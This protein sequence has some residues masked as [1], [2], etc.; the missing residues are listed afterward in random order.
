[1]L[2][3]AIRGAIKKSPFSRNKNLA[4]FSGQSHIIGIDLGTTN[5]CV[6]VVEGGETIIIENSEGERTTPSVVAFTKEGEILVGST[7]KRQAVTNPTDTFYA[8]KR[9]IGRKW[10][11]KEIQ[12]DIQNLGYNVIKH[13]NG[14]AWVQRST[15][16]TYS[17]SQIGAFVLGKMKETAE[18]YLG[19]QINSAVIT[20][21]AYFNDS[22]RQATKDAGVIAGLKV[23][24]IINEPTAAA[25]AYGLEKEQDMNLAVYDLGGGTFDISI[26][27]MTGGVFEVKSTN[28]D[29]S[30]GGEDLDS[31]ILNYVIARYLAETGINLKGDRVATQRIREAAEKAKMELSSAK[32]TEIN[33]PYITMNEQG[34]QNLAMTITRDQF[35]KIIGDFV[36]RTLEP[37][38]ISLRDAQMSIGDID[39][40][41]LVG[42]STRIP[43]VQELVKDFYGKQPSKGVNPDEAVAFGAAIQSGIMEGGFEGIVLIDVVPLSL[44]TEVVGGIFSKIIERNQAIPCSNSQIYTTTEDNQTSI[45]FPVYQGERE[46]AKEN[47]HLGEF[48]LGGLAPAP[49][50]VAKV[51]ASM[52]IDNNGILNVTAKDVSTGKEASITIQPSG[53]LSQNEIERMVREG[54]RA[55]AQ[56][57]AKRAVIEAKNQLDQSIHQSRQALSEFGDRIPAEEKTNIE[58]KITEFE[59]V[60]NDSNSSTEVLES[61]VK[62]LNSEVM[63]I[64][65]LVYGGQQQSS[66]GSGNQENK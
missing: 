41:I 66:G 50:G 46:I 43:M 61:S 54:E 63:R 10:Q 37:C 38:K 14:D 49:R 30:C 31:L 6:S 39:S 60:L 42:G 40:V 8:T 59:A 15:G 55:K 16:E 20:V 28:G 9:L 57:A 58:N 62:K 25:M 18:S 1:M 36:K 24:R 5:S 3:K 27:E 33:L 45:S 12:E 48:T 7:A 44:G 21:P 22:Q 19:S 51:E 53:G 26:L 29:T 17:P 23:E 2:R 4:S 13:S 34:P 64:G 65:S 52:Q 11:D 56:D 32:S 47:K 35:N